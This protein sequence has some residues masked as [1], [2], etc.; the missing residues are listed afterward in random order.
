MKAAGFAGALMICLAGGA[1]RA[2]TTTTTFQV[3]ATVIA[4]CA[5]SASD[6]A[7][8]SYDT[9]TGSAV[10]GSTTVAVTCSSGTSYEI[11]LDAGLGTGATVTTRKMSNGG[12]TLNYSLYTDAAHTTVWGET[13]SVDTVASTGTGSAQNFTVY[14]LIAASQVV[15]TGSYADTITVTVTF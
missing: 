12:N 6:L 13:A 11:G 4:S 9:V 2:G 10:S 14:G 5:V 8:G 3:T 1:A 7:F 15:A